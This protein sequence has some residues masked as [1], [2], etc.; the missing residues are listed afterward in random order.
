MSY[1]KPTI[2]TYRFNNAAGSP[3]PV[4]SSV[5]AA[6]VIANTVSGIIDQTKRRQFEQQIT[7]LSSSQQIQLAN[8]IQNETNLNDKLAVLN[9]GV[10][11]Y[12]AQTSNQSQMNTIILIVVAVAAL[13]GTLYFVMK[14]KT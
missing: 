6:A 4:T 2:V 10:F 11:G 14:N 9:D 1:V 8:R 5:Q 12:L 13:L 7:L 3:D